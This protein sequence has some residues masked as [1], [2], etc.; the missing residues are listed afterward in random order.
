MPH[1]I[2]VFLYHHSVT[3][4]MYN[5]IR[6][7]RHDS[8]KSMCDYDF[9]QW[10]FTKRTGKKLDIGNP[11]T[12]DE[13]IWYL[14]LYDHNELKPKCTEKYN[15]REY[16]KECGLEHILNDVYGLYEHFDEIEFDKL[17]NEFFIKCTHT[18]GCNV[19]YS[20]ASQFDMRYYRN[21]F[22]FWLKRS[23]YWI[24]R[25]WNYKDI[26]ARII[27]EPVLRDSLGKLPID[28]KFF[29]FG[30]KV[31]I[32][33]I[34][35]GVADENGEHS[36]NYYRNIYNREFKL[37]P[38]KETREIYGGT[39][40]RPE[41]YDKMVEYAE[42]LSK[43]FRHCRV[44]L[45]NV[46]GRIYFGEITFHHGSGCNNFEPQE[47]DEKLGDLINIEGLKINE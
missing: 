47:W 33:S 40:P 14:T 34:D 29:C 12:F 13:K 7:Y 19:I 28:Y 32:V 11:R 31:E 4:K 43:P 10:Y 21:E 3:A 26:P 22:E 8:K 25:E 20:K 1:P 41:N 37:L 39:V 46:E 35:I 23:Y 16:V 5:V 17:P 9:A 30:G 27:C 2:K 38:V 24:G 18:S 45:Y 44:D 36:E 42:I 6:N 15:V